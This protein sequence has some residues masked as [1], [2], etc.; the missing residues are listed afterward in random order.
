[1]LRKIH[2]RA[3]R[4]LKTRSSE[5]SEDGRRNGMSMA[6]VLARLVETRDNN[7]VLLPW[8]VLHAGVIITRYIESS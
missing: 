2:G 3:T 8:L 6:G 5:R 7:H 1:M 4:R